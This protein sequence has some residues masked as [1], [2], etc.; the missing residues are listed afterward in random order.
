M[1]QF[2]INDFQSISDARL[3][4]D[5]I[6]VIVGESN[7]GKSACLRAIQAACTNR[8]KAGQVKQGK[9]Q[10]LIKIKTPESDE[11]LS[12]ARSWSGGSPK[13]KLGGRV[14]SKLGRTLPSEIS[15]FL[16][17][18]FFD[19]NGEQYSC[20]FHSQF[21]KP[22]LLEYSQQKVM[23]LL[24]ASTSLDD[25]KEC[26]EYLM[27]ERAKNK[28]AIQVV[29]SIIE[30]TLFKQK[31]VQ[32]KIDEVKPLVDEFSVVYDNYQALVE[33]YS[34]TQ[35]LL[36]SVDSYEML[37]KV[38][39]NLAQITDIYESLNKVKFLLS[40]IEQLENSRILLSKFDYKSRIYFEYISLYDPDQDTNY[41][42]VAELVELV[43]TIY[44][45]D[46]KLEQLIKKCELC[47][48]YLKVKDSIQDIGN[49]KYDVRE[50]ESKHEYYKIVEH[51][52]NELLKI[53]EQNIC[54]ICGNKVSI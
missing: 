30:E 38:S 25:L 19:F 6:T 39:Y 52:E 20:N 12:V 48:E 41:R 26:K 16:K 33:Q 50:L 28:G 15:D 3:K 43:E 54:P 47:S 13:M 44:V 2:I 45:Q 7:Q 23:E 18:G 4:V 5:G 34:T 14:Y 11:V 42:N 51:N 10:A 40:I 49:K 29:D 31:E 1:I 32:L 35:E 9:D 24:S 36:D 53:V 22:L 17:L 27:S 8:F 37:T 46:R 21:Q